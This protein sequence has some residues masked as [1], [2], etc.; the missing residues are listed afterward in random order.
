MRHHR[1]K[2][3]R[4]GDQEKLV[5]AM[6]ATGKPVVLVLFGGRNQVI[7]PFADRCAAVLQ[8]WYPGEEGGRAV[9]EI[10]AGTVNPSGRL[11]MTYPKTESR[12]PLTFGDGSDTPDR[13]QWPFGHGL[14]YTK[15]EY[16]Q[17]EL[18]S[19]AATRIGSAGDCVEVAVTIKNVGAKAGA[20]VIQLYITAK[21]EPVR[22]RGFARVA[23][24][25]GESKRVAFS[26]PLELF[27]RWRGDN[28]G[29][30]SVE[31][32]EYEIR[33]ARDAWDKSHVL[34]VRLEGNPIRFPRR[35]FFRFFSAA[36]VE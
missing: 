19:G 12:D 13:V 28:N 5:E 14:S 17:A 4:V 32:G 9:A 24:A 33:L 10:L 1:R 16:A 35:T 20:E 26:V 31:P 22:L 27:A 30:W 8:A 34:H 18:A 2:S 25:P 23:L 11:P 6:L 7:S 36:R 29:A 15:F 3:R 21:G